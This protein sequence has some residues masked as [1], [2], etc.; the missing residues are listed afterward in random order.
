MGAIALLVLPGRWRGPQWWDRLILLAY[1]LVYLT[2]A[3][4]RGR[5]AGT[6]QSWTKKEVALAETG[7]AALAVGA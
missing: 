4:L 3:L 7:G 1:Y 5:H 2:R 6:E